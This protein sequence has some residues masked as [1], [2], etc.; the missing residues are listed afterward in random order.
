M[1]QQREPYFAGSPEIL[2]VTGVHIGWPNFVTRLA[3]IYGYLGA[4]ERPI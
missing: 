4:F 2:L 1:L 3:M